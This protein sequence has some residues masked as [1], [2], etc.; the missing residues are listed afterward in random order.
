MGN[1]EQFTN[2]EPLDPEFV[3]QFLTR[4]DPGD[5]LIINRNI[6]NSPAWYA[7]TLWEVAT[8]YPVQIFTAHA[9]EN[10]YMQS[11]EVFVEFTEDDIAIAKFDVDLNFPIILTK[12]R[13]N[14]DDIIVDGY[15]RVY[16]AR[17]SGEQLKYVVLPVMPAPDILN[18]HHTKEA[19]LRIEERV[20]KFD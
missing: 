19:L 13:S 8:N 16:K 5:K 15:H 3:K 6:V 20:S 18:N 7:R 4:M 9:V 1:A 14:N 11:E 2:Y 10:L 17:H 12:D